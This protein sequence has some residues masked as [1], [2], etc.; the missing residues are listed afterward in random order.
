MKLQ[1]NLK[2]KN[3]F[4][5]NNTKGST[6]VALII[7]IVILLILAVV[8]ILKQKFWDENVTEKEDNSTVKFSSTGNE[9]DA[10]GEHTLKIGDFVKYNVSYTDV[11]INKEYTADNGWRYLGK[12]ESGNNLIISTGIPAM[13]YYSTSDSNNNTWWVKEDSTGEDGTTS[14]KATLEEFK[15]LLNGNNDD[16]TFY[17]GNNSGCKSLQAS[18]GLYYNFGDINF[19]YAT[20]SS[21]D[22]Y[23]KGFYTSITSNDKT[24]NNTNNVTEV[25]ANDLFN[26]HKDKSI[27]RLLTL[28]EVNKAIERE[29][30]IDSTSRIQPTDEKSKNAEAVGLYRLDQLK[31]ISSMND[32]NYSLTGYYWLASPYPC[33]Y[34]RTYVC[35]VGYDGNFH[36]SLDFYYGVRPVVVLQSDIPLERS[37]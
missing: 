12:D 21:S 34:Y 14:R 20:S 23:N 31:N 24:Y 5:H 30:D 11:Y 18:A 17:N 36:S 26:L 4:K 8:T 32:Y 3:Y 25:T 6:L 35:L 1:L 7:I 13:L 15:E 2:K 19:K 9:Y 28:P 22:L 37:N 16:Y 27:V 29:T 33:A 10:E